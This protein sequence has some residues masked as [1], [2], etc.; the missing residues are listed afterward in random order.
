[1]PEQPEAREPLPATD[2]PAGDVSVT[3]L[4]GGHAYWRALY[5][6]NLYRLLLATGMVTLAVTSAEVAVIGQSHP[7]LFLAASTAMLLFAVVN[8]IT[9]TT[10][11]PPFRVQAYLQFALDA[12]LITAMS[13]ASGGVDSGLNLLLIASIAAGGVV[14]SGRMSLFFAAFA[15]LLALVQRSLEV[16]QY[17]AW[18]QG[19]DFI[20]VGLLGI[21]YFSTGWMVYWLARRFHAMEAEAQA[22]EATSAR[23]DR[24]NEAI[25][26]KSTVGIAVLSHDQRCRLVN[27]QARR[28]LGLSATGRTLPASLIELVQEHGAGPDSFSFEYRSP[29]T[30]LRVQGLR[31][32]DREDEVALFLEDLAQAEREARNLKLAALG[33]LTASVA[34]EIRNPLEAISHAGQ[35]LAESPDLSAQQKKLTTI[36]E[37]QSNRIETIVKSIL[38][39]GRPGAVQRVDL[40]IQPWLERFRDYF[41]VVHDIEDAL[42]VETGDLVVCVDPDQLNQILTNLCENALRHTRHLGTRPLITIKCFPDPRSG[43]VCLEIHDRG[44]GVS[45]DIRDKIFEPFFT[46]NHYGMGLGLFLAR[47]LAEHNQGELDYFQTN[48]AGYFRLILEAGAASEVR[49]G[50]GAGHG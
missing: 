3:R 13:H 42:A 25:V 49:D 23:L 26:S 36:V 40:R 45:E 37:N 21:G 11:W 12:V 39:L 19:G 31:I 7:T 47:E 22:R 38:Q 35:L 17:D 43:G 4:Q 16:L 14:L 27:E 24:L 9:I 33:R 15:T 18:T 44:E 5:Y 29:V 8:L 20:Q 46:T 10:S 2:E 34:H 28:M 48:G 6:F 32:D 41:N 30:R 50:L 1:M